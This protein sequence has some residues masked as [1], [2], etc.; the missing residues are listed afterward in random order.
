MTEESTQDWA[1]RYTERQERKSAWIAPQD[2]PEGEP[3]GADDALVTS[4]NDSR[5]G[6]GQRAASAY[7]GW[8]EA[9]EDFPVSQL[10]EKSKRQL[11][12]YAATTTYLILWLPRRRCRR[13]LLP[14]RT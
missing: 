5:E 8:D 4:G 11:S 7:P 14:A 3:H 12:K 13:S 1:E 6:A 9:Q 10:P 2:K